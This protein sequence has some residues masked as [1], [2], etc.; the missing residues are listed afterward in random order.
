MLICQSVK[1]IV[2]LYEVLFLVNCLITLFCIGM[3]VIIILSSKLQ[4]DFKTKSS[5]TL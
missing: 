4:F 5:T 2:G 3:V 1:I